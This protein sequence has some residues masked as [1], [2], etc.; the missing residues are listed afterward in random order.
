MIIWW[1][2]TKIRKTK[3]RILPLIE[4]EKHTE[5]LEIYNIFIGGKEEWI[6]SLLCK[7]WTILQNYKNK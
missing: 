7:L 6:N 2:S 5:M 3:G 1:K 4:N